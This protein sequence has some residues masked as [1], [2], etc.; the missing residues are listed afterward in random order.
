MTVPLGAV[1][2]VRVTSIR[3]SARFI[4]LSA[5]LSACGST[6]SPT[7][8][9]FGWTHRAA[10]EGQVLTQSDEPLVGAFVALRVKPGRPGA[11]YPMPDTKTDG[12][13]HFELGVV[14]VPTGNVPVGPTDTVTAYVVAAGGPEFPDGSLPTDST[15]VILHFV[16]RDGPPPSPTTVT[17]H[18]PVP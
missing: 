3:A 14:R 7:G 9:Q 6:R 4:V 11:T 15:R 12:E 8:E 16:S 10:V 5:A 17:V 18:V 1:S 13:G 2:F